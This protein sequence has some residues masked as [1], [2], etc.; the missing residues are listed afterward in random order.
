MN[1]IQEKAI[2]NKQP[3]VSHNL[4]KRQITSAAKLHQPMYSTHVISGKKLQISSKFPL[5][6]KRK[7]NIEN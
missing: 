2:Q 7:Y 5:L 1:T 4:K 6:L 3:Q